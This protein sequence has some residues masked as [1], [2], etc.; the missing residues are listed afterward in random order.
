[1]VPKSQL[2]SQVHDKS[3]N[4]NVLLFKYKNSYIK[5]EEVYDILL[6][7]YNTSIYVSL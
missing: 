2:E 4:I 5:F 1:M 7:K 6:F 3:V